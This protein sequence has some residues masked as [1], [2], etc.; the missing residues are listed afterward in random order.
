MTGD[1]AIARLI[2]G[3]KSFRATYY[4]Q[5]PERIQQLIEEGQRPEV[6][7]VACS[8]ARV[9]PALLLQLEPGELFVVRNV[10]NLVP[11]YAP[12][13]HYHGTSAALEFAVRD[14]AVSHV[15]VLGHSGCGGIEALIGAEAGATG[16]PRDFIASWMSIAQAA[17]DEVDHGA[18]E[19]GQ[20][21]HDYTARAVEQAVI[22]MSLAN[23]LTFPWIRAR[24][25]D[26]T[27]ALHGWWFDL[28]AGELRGVRGPSE[29]LSRLG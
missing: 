27:L 21:D 5:R 8:D 23:L 11:P 2:A 7:V 28:A 14:L 3:F 20:N 22:R 4:E 24:V 26:D 18:K 25:E 6:A 15:V 1:R 16:E 17:R 13:S 9:D 10:A 29:T 12:D 19:G